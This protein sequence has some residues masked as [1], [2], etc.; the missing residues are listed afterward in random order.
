MQ[1]KYQEVTIV[2]VAGAILFMVFAGVI[3]YFLFLN[4]KKKFRHAQDIS[5]IKEQYKAEM[6]SAQLEIQEQTFNHI[7][8]EIHDN[9]G[10]VLSLAKVQINIMNESEDMNREMLNEVKQNIGKAMVD[11]RDIAKS[12]NSDYIRTLSIDEVVAKEAERINKS[13]IIQVTVSASGEERK[14]V[15]QKKLILF[16]IIQESI[17]NIIKHAN[18]SEV[19][20]NFNY[21]A[22]LLQTTIVDNGK[23]FTQTDGYTKS[24]GLG[25]SNIRTRAGLTGGTSSID[26]TPGKGTIINVSIPYE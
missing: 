18:A 11:L 21:A 19:V 9:V 5:T 2:V 24:D 8:Q 10:Q 17:Q 15:E 14:M 23:G 12:L 1:D 7:S 4:Q 3:I 20:I 16:R 25:L 13:G 6:L 22:D 26:S